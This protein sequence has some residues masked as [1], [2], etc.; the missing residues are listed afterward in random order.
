MHALVLQMLLSVHLGPMA[1]DAPARSPQLAA[2]QSMIALTFGA[3][4]GIYFSAS[5]DNGKTFLTPVKVGEGG[6]VPLS[7]HR[8]PHIALSGSTIVISAIVG[9]KMAEG[10]HAHGLPADGDLFVWRSLNGGKNWSKGTMVND[11]PGAPT[12][13]LHSLAADAGGNLFL[14]WLDKRTGAGTQL[15]GARSTD[16]GAT[17]SGNVLIYQSPDGTVCQCCSPAAAID[18][19]GQILVMWRNWLAGARDMY[20]ARSRDGLVFSKAE[21]LGAG[22]WQLNAVY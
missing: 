3:G 6:V 7:R 10:P 18:A 15:Y 21:K 4:N 5:H 1:P 14:A 22:S 13:G 11:V 8:G 16:G 20:L 12:E 2:N 17:W 9:R 19:S